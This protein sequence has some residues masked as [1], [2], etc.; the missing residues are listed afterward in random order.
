MSIDDRKQETD[1]IVLMHHFVTKVLLLKG[2]KVSYQDNYKR[3]D[4]IQCSSHRSVE[5]VTESL[6]RVEAQVTRHGENLRE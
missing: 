1:Q 2:A 4:I 3:V 5:A 6:L